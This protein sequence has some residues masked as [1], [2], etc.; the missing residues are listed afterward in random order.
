MPIT[1][2]AVAF[3]ALSLLML[4]VQHRTES[5][6]LRLAVKLLFVGF[7]GAAIYRT[8]D[9]GWGGSNSIPVA[10]SLINKGR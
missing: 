1:T 5:F 8:F 7:L 3:A 2:V 9:S 6:L 10:L 4:Y